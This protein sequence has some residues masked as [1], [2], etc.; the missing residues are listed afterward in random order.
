VPGADAAEDP[1]AGLAA[2]P[3]NDGAPDRVPL[4]LA[5]AYAAVPD[6]RPGPSIARAAVMGSL[7]DRARPGGEA[8]DRA[9][10]TGPVTVV[11]KTAARLTSAEPDKPRGVIRTATPV[12]AGARFDDPWL[13]AAMFAPSLYTSLT[14][15]SYSEPDFTELR[16]LMHKPTTT[17]VMTFSG[18]PLHGLK[19]ERFSG[20]AVVFLATVTFQRT[21]HLY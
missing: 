14:T 10:D 21:A 17:V 1:T 4:E 18:D 7:V 15:T 3:H 5:L 12:A 6:E 20:G 8:R 16:P 2:W 9:A 13:R 11:K 19:C